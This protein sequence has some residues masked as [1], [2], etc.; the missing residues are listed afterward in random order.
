MASEDT[1][2]WSDND[3]I[4]VL[5]NPL[6]NFRQSIQRSHIVWKLPLQ[7]KTEVGFVRWKVNFPQPKILC[8]WRQR[9]RDLWRLVNLANGMT[10]EA[11]RINI[12]RSYTVTS[13]L[14]PR[15]PNKAG[16]T[17]KPTHKDWSGTFQS[18]QTY[19]IDNFRNCKCFLLTY[20][21]WNDSNF[22]IFARVKLSL[23]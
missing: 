8:S 1:E 18:L 16:V 10:F 12:G 19:C 9:V 17:C 21:K 6:H 23:L 11:S 13:V 20:K 14:V 4:S 7:P 5:T 22:I 2:K 15:F 3:Y